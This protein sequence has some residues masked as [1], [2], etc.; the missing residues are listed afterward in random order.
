VRTLVRGFG[1]LDRRHRVRSKSGLTGWVLVSCLAVQSVPGATVAV[2][3][4]PGAMAAKAPSRSDEIAAAAT[5]LDGVETMVVGTIDAETLQGCDALILPNERGSAQVSKTNRAFLRD[6][7]TA[8]HG[9]VCTHDAVGYRSHV[10]LFPEI[11]V[12]SGN[13]Y[14]TQQAYKN[15][16]CVVAQH[17]VLSDGMTLK[18]HCTSS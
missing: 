16:F 13:F 15:Q 12:G 3:K 18:Q 14:T 8:G 2:Y 17:P 6:W 5:G 9:L 1:K 4:D 7:V 10:P 11:A